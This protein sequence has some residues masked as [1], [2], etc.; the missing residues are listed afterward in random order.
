MQK[1]VNTQAETSSNNKNKNNL[2]KPTVTLASNICFN[3][4]NIRNASSLAANSSCWYLRAFLSD[5]I[6]LAA[7]SLAVFRMISA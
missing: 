2:K 5:N 7:A 6:I 4:S 1:A 3:L